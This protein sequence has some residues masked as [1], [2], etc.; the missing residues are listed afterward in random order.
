MALEVDLPTAL[1]V[2]ALTTYA[3]RIGGVVI[4]RWIPLSRRVQRF[5]EALSGSVL[6]A[7][8]APM[9]LAGDLG[10]KLALAVAA[11]TMLATRNA[12]AAIAAAMLAVVILRAVL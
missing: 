12:A 2:M 6:V 4:M 10:F 5:L 7:L 3:T 1:A 8:V 9:A 11:G